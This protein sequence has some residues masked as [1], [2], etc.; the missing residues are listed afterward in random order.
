M[1]MASVALISVVLML[2]ALTTVIGVPVVVM[3]TVLMTTAMHP[4]VAGSVTASRPRR[5]T[6]EVR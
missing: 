6:G 3:T 2:G 1:T 5:S 4:V